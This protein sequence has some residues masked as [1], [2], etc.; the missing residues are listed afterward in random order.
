[1]TIRFRLGNSAPLRWSARRICARGLPLASFA[2][3]RPRGRQGNRSAGPAIGPERPFGIPPRRSPRTRRSSSSRSFPIIGRERQNSALP[4]P[5]VLSRFAYLR[6]RGNE[7]VLELPRAG[8][9]FRI[10][11]PE[12][13]AA[14]AT[15]ASPQ[16]ISRLRRQDG[17]PGM[18]LLA[19]LVD[20]QIL[21]KIDAV[22]QRW[23]PAGRG[24]RQPRALGLSRSSVSH[25][26]YGRPP[27]QSARRTL[28]ICGSDSAAAGGAAALA[29]KENRS[30]QA[31][32]RTARLPLT[33]CRTAA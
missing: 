4:K 25:P 32:G 10:C 21:F 2:A 26:L 33:L 8:A 1:M 16:K 31:F 7:M 30:A 9:L 5:I 14:L 19:L 15:L 28:S 6:R 22:A 20:C 23:P 3:E 27:G 12:L 24:R 17:F 11:D 18:E 29:G 13:A